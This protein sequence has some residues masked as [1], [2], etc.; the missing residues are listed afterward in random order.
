MKYS[1]FNQTANDAT[2]E[3]MFFGQPVN[4]L[5]FDKQRYPFFEQLTE[6]QVSFF[7][8]PEEV[9]L[10]KDRI[11]FQALSA[12]EQHIFTSNLKYQT[13]LDSVQGRSPNSV[14]LPLVSLPEL[15][16]WIETWSFFEAAI[17]AKSYTHII[18]NIYNEPSAVLDDIMVNPAILERADALSK[19][20]DDLHELSLDYQ[21]GKPVDMRELKKRLLLCMVAINVLE[22]VRFYV[23]FACSFAFAER[24]LMEGNAKIIKM[25]CRDELIHLNGTQTIL[26]LLAQEDEE[27]AELWELYKNDIYDI[28]WNA[29]EQEKLW[30][31]YLF[32]D[33]SMIGLSK[34]ILTQYLEYITSVRMQAIGLKPYF[35]TKN[36]ITWI[37]S[38]TTSDNVQVAPQETEITSYLVG[39]IDADLGDADFSD[40]E[41]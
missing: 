9:D 38:W 13:V 15:E 39:Q 3:P 25:I 5:R 33:G 11:D 18:R 24:K 19:Y 32:K 10:S 14:L 30:I 20:Y 36:P 12:T 26:R 17:H 23:S 8:R 6:R 4:V 7:W 41:I 40:M 2:Q 22:G 1:V 21:Q 31:E 37:N 16:A 34:D 29:Y 27:F 35:T 28:F